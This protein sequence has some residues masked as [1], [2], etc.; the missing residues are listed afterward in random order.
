MT[1]QEN[2]KKDYYKILEVEPEAEP[3]VIEKAHTTPNANRAEL[4]QD[5][6]ESVIGS[7]ENEVENLTDQ[8]AKISLDTGP[9]LRKI[10]HI[11]PIRTPRPR[12]HLNRR[13]ITDGLARCGLA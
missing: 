4:A 13:G 5:T 10:H 6:E 9:L 2:K 12:G 11:C 3:L 7:V 1:S 8:I